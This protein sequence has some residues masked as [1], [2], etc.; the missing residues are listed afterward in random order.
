M[1]NAMLRVLRSDGC[2]NLLSAVIGNPFRDNDPEKVPKNNVILNRISVERLGRY[3]Y[4]IVIIAN[5]WH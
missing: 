3:T 1:L 5:R 2:K 4:V